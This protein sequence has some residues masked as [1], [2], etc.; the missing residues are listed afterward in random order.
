[1][2][3]MPA[4]LIITATSGNSADAFRVCVSMLYRTFLLIFSLATGHCIKSSSSKTIF[5]D[6]FNRADGNPGANYTI[7]LPGGTT[8]NIMSQMAYPVFNGAAPALIYNQEITTGFKASAN[9]KI[10]GGTFTGI[11]YI[12]GR[13]TSSASLDN[14]YACGYNNGNLVTG[15]FSSGTLTTIATL[16]LAT[17]ASGNVDNITFT[18][19]GTTITCAI[20]GVNNFSVTFFDGTYTQGYAGLLGGGATGNYLYFDDLDLEKL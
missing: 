15:I 20:S 4:S 12:A 10:I 14:S 6:D 3:I 19:D 5:K 9:L 11:G 13:S 1:M 18:L 17:L 8:F 2:T 16:P 7:Y